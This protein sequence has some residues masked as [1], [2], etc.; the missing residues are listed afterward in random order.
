MFYDLLGGGGGD[1]IRSLPRLFCDEIK[2]PQTVTFF[3]K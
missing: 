1:K 2:P 3:E